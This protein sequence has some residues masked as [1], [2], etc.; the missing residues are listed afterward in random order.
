MKNSWLKILAGCL[1]GI[2]LL[3]VMLG[4]GGFVH[5]LLFNGLGV[6]LI[7]FVSFYRRRVRQ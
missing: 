1:L 5:L 6:L 2:W 4:K 3:L 7:D